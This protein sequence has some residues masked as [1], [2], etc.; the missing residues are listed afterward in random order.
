MKQLAIPFTDLQDIPSGHFHAFL[1]CNSADN[2]FYK[3]PF[4]SLKNEIL[5]KYGN[6]SDYDLQIIKKVCYSC[7]GKGNH[8]TGKACRNCEKGIY[9]TKKVILK[10]YILNGALFHEPVG[11]MRFN[12]HELKVFNGYDEDFCP[13]FR[14]V[15]FEGIIVNQINGIIKHEP[16]NLNATWAYYY[17]VWKYKPETFLSLIASNL[18][19]YNTNTQHKIKKLLKKYSPL[20][21]FAEFFDVKKEQLEPIE[22]LPF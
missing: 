2:W 22:D 5:K 10:R 17:L 4:Y 3:Q 11:E 12:N 6:E 14:Y 7:D 16:I 8:H 21:A 18:K 15:P 13:K 19:H 20:K 1:V 9:Q